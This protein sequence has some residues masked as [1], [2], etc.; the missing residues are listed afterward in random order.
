MPPSRYG[1]GRST[2]KITAGHVPPGDAGPRLGL[3]VVAA[4]DFFGDT[5][6]QHQAQGQTKLPWTGKASRSPRRTNPL[7]RDPTED[8]FYAEDPRHRHA[9]NPKPIPARSSHWGS[10]TRG[11]E[12]PRVHSWRRSI[13]E[14]HM[15]TGP[16]WRGIPRAPSTAA[17]CCHSDR[18]GSEPPADPRAEY[19]DQQ[20]QEPA[21]T[22][23]NKRQPARRWSLLEV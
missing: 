4:Q 18:D 3:E 8:P 7:D 22:A 5:N 17:C 14:L 6:Q 19:Q 21:N 15:T 9:P 2:A 1:R 11:P 16:L 10:S 23:D 12:K 20:Q 13:H